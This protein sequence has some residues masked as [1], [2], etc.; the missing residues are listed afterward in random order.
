MNLL[1]GLRLGLIEIRAHKLRAFLTLS[2]IAVGITSVVA[3]TGI[4]SCVQRGMRK[5]VAQA[6][7]GRLFIGQQATSD[8]SNRSTGLIYEDAVALRRHFPSARAVSPIASTSTSAFYREFR[9]RVEVAGIFPDWA[10]L[11][12]N[13]KVRGR[14]FNDADLRDAAPVCVLVK[15]LYGKD[16]AQDDPLAPLFR[17]YDPLRQ[18][19][20]L[21][22]T[23]FRVIGILEDLPK[24]D[25]FMGGN[26]ATVLLPLTS[27]QKRL[28]FERRQID[29]INVDSGDQAS[30]YIL[31]KQ[32]AGFLKRR[33]RGVEDI[34]VMNVVDFMG[35]MLSW[36]NMATFI[37]GAVGAIALFAGGVGIMNITLASVHA[38]IK[39]IGIRKS[40]GAR[41]RDIRLQF[42]AEATLLSLLG[43]VS[44]V[45]LGGVLCFLVKLATKMNIILSPA[46]IATALLTSIGVGLAFSWYPAR[47]ASRLDPVEALRCE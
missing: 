45:V 30:S 38:R 11:D 17:R 13:Y 33:H 46:A 18:T 14:F 4:L 29:M 34:Q 9:A 19:I 31:A 36:L 5:S 8:H 10:K 27:F 23:L 25:G 37:I 2:G 12:W 43:G 16:G 28:S 42:L 20:R 24:D 44:G 6:G 35:P 1:E 3:L 40:L 47:R 39:E 22:G 41:E 7:L 32:V 21:G 26:N 15:K